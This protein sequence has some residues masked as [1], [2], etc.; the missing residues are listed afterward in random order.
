M[1]GGS[2]SNRRPPSSCSAAAS[3]CDLRLTLMVNVVSKDADNS[4][5]EGSEMRAREI[6]CERM[7]RPRELVASGGALDG[8]AY[9]ATIARCSK[10]QASP[11]AESIIP[12][13]FIP[14]LR[15]HA[16]AKMAAGPQAASPSLA[17][18]PHATPAPSLDQASVDSMFWVRADQ[19]TLCVSIHEVA[20]ALNFCF[21]MAPLRFKVR[22]CCPSV[23][24][25]AASDANV[26]RHII[27]SGWCQVGRTVLLLFPSLDS[28]I[29]AG[30]KN[31][32]AIVTSSP[33]Q[34][35]GGAEGSVFP[36]L[37]PRSPFKAPAGGRHR[38]AHSLPPPH[39]QC[40]RCLATDHL[41][42][43]CRDPV[44]C[45]AC[46]RNGHRSTSCCMAGSLSSAIWPRRSARSPSSEDSSSPPPANRRR[47]LL[48]SEQLG[49]LPPSTDAG[50]GAPLFHSPLSPMPFHLLPQPDTITL[51]PVCCIHDA[52]LCCIHDVRVLVLVDEQKKIKPELLVRNPCGEV[53]GIA[54]L[55]VVGD[56]PHQAGAPAPDHHDFSDDTT[57]GPPM[58]GPYTPGTGWADLSRGST[59]RSRSS[60]FSSSGSTLRGGTCR[61][62]GSCLYPS[63]PLWTF[64]SGAF[65][66]LARALSL[67][68][69]PTITI[70]DLPTPVRPRTPP[71]PEAPTLVR[72]D[73]NI[74]GQ[75]TLPRIPSLRE[76]LE[77]EAN[78]ASLRKRRVRR[79]RAKDS[80]SK[81]RRSSRLAALEPPHY[82]DATS[83]AT[84]VKAVKLDISK[85]SMKMRAAIVDAGLLERP[86]PAK[87]KSSKL[88]RL[89][90]VCGLGNMSEIVD[91]E[92]PCT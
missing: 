50:A 75:G 33:I 86:P 30:T 58:S 19:G 68:G 12:L 70:R 60:H 26:A 77:E 63:A 32:D 55:R 56:W 59:T 57:F 3:R 10:P 69:V 20:N 72:R 4:S 89:G 54:S 52:C 90:H 27:T 53:A 18:A 15:M 39:T 17:P 36:P 80:V 6:T 48:L 47:H 51:Q 61:T 65:A 22:Q 28:A 14:A 5:P 7:A 21:S 23:F 29:A 66:A 92:V 84:R 1:E 31:A 67:A 87:V 42:A 25:S 88:H 49:S 2:T 24:A 62:V 74:I 46:L 41:V 13:L 76:I 71:P 45:R 40:F 38:R 16:Q 85:V 9:D 78:E 64:A 8:E 11:T 73:E 81:L 44:R 34:I 43:S 37:N 35:G 79:K 82:E 83:K 91:D